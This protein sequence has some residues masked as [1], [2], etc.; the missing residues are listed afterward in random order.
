VRNLHGD[1]EE[2]DGKFQVSLA[3][4]NGEGP[5]NRSVEVK[6]STSLLSGLLDL[7]QLN[8]CYKDNLLDPFF[9]EDNQT[10]RQ[11]TSDKLFNE[12]LECKANTEFTAT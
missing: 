10:C 9:E 3:G 1:L 4:V 8:I 11:I 12:H 6:Q 7:K 5:S 2:I